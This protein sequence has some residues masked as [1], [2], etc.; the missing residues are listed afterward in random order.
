MPSAS[1]ASSTSGQAPAAPGAKPPPPAAASAGRAADPSPRSCP[2]TAAAGRRMRSRW[3]PAAPEPPPPPPPPLAPP[4]TMT[5][6]TGAASAVATSARSSGLVRDALLAP[7]SLSA[8]EEAPAPSSA[9]GRRRSM[10]SWGVGVPCCVGPLSG[11]CPLLV[12]RN[13]SDSR[14]QAHRIAHPQRGGARDRHSTITPRRSPPVGAGR[15]R[16][17]TAPR[18]RRT[19]RDGAH[20]RPRSCYC[21]A[22]AAGGP[23]R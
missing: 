3:P 19:A 16:A 21:A 15:P 5:Y 11:A 4:P 23:T 18:A 6:A 22:A 20:R 2:P 14:S 7:S 1:S 10:L 12:G 9:A 13:T 17:V 8:R